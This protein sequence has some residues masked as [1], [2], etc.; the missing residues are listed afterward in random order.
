MKVLEPIS[1]GVSSPVP[2]SNGS[3]LMVPAKEIM[4]RSPLSALPPS[5]F[6]VKG[7]FCSAMRESASS[8]SA[9]ATSLTGRVSLMVLKSASSIGGTTSTAML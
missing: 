5:A 6:G 7:L 2:P 3:P 4:T 1:T 9:S 8:I